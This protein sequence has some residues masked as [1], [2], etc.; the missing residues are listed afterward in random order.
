MEDGR[1]VSMEVMK[2][3]SLIC[4]KNFKKDLS[5]YTILNSFH[6]YPSASIGWLHLH[7]YVGELLTS[8]HD[9]MENK[10]LEKGPS[11]RKN[12]PYQEVVDYLQEDE[13]DGTMLIRTDSV[14]R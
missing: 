6:A 10:E 3:S 11:I 8:A 7:S 12:T 1:K 4:K 2:G 9:T 13:D 14:C 5:D